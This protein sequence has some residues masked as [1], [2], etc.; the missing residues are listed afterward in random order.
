MYISLTWQPEKGDCVKRM[1]ERFFNPTSRQAV[2]F[3]VAALV[4]FAVA[5]FKA[6]LIPDTVLF[7]S[8]DNIGIIENVRNR[9]PLAFLSNWDDSVF[10]GSPGGLAA[11]TLNSMLM[12]LLPTRI[13]INWIHAIDLVLASIGLALFLRAAGMSWAATALG[14]MTAFWTGSN[15]TLTYAGHL[16]K[17][18]LFIFLALA[19]YGIRMTFESKHPWLWSIITGGC[20]ALMLMEQQDVALFCGIFLGAYAMF[21]L[22]RI[23][24]GLGRI[25]AL[26]YFAPMVFVALL[27][28]GANLIAIYTANVEKTD[29]KRDANS[30]R[31]WDFVT[32]WSWPPEE[33]IDFIAPGYMGWRSGEPSGP[34]WGR[35]GRTAGWEQTGQGFMNF[36]LENQYLGVVPIAFALFAVMVALMR[37]NGGGQSGPQQAVP[38]DNKARAEIIFWFCAALLALLLSFGKYFPLYEL[39][40]QLPVVHSIRNPNKFLH[41]FQLALGILAAYGVQAA[42]AWGRKEKP[43]RIA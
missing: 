12:W 39:F 19:L 29:M 11:L 40:Y 23:S 28:S 35:M 30:S 7:S 37:G 41:I 36:K 15:L 24:D 13:Y 6:L 2:C 31:E 38:A 34:Y 43:S 27:I 21:L 5:M 3:A 18:G 9:F 17:F 42:V 14:V 10:F 32:Q 26:F 1:P 22:A 33:S 25:K 8:D 20:L 4:L 16:G